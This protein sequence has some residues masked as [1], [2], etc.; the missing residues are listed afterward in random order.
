MIYE[1]PLI[2][3]QSKNK[4]KITK[5]FCVQICSDLQFVILILIQFKRK[6]NHDD[7]DD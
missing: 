4:Q 2:S 5:E 6:H 3:V 1:Q 7:A